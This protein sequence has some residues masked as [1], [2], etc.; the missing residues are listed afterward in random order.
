MIVANSESHALPII[1]RDPSTVY[2]N[3]RIARMYH[4]AGLLEVH[5]ESN[6]YAFP[7]RMPLNDVD[8]SVDATNFLQVFRSCSESCIPK[9]RCPKGDTG[10]WRNDVT[11]ACQE[12]GA[13]TARSASRLCPLRYNRWSGKSF[14]RVWL[15]QEIVSDCWCEAS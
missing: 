4:S 8:M 6:L 12:G 5:F 15:V 2:M 14:M 1:T 10:H 7:R 3:L 13:K 11:S 9:L